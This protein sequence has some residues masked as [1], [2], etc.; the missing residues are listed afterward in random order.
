MYLLRPG[1][2]QTP[3]DILGPSISTDQC[4]M[5]NEYVRM[6]LDRGHNICRGLLPVGTE[7]PIQI[8]S[9]YS[10]FEYVCVCVC[11]QAIDHC[12]SLVRVY[13]MM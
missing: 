2:Q 8:T 9:A 5:I 3:A 7:H 12:D 6:H 4:L 10:V 11:A 13:L 1:R